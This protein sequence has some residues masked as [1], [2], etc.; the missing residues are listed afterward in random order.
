ME[1]VRLATTD[2]YDLVLMDMRMPGMDGLEAT[3][4]IRALP[5]SRGQVPIVAMTANALDQH[6]EECRLAGMVEHLAKPVTQAE[7]LAVVTR[8]AAAFP[9]I[10]LPVMDVDTMAQLENCM[11]SDEVHWLLD[12]LTLRIEALVKKLGEDDPFA[13]S[14]GLAEL[15]HEMA[16]SAGTLGFIRLSAAASRFDGAISRDP[17]LAPRMVREILDEASAALAELRRPRSA[18]SRLFA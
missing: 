17:G 18:G 3:R 16:G 5:G 9:R 11:S 4:R 6:A 13:A 1:A 14:D 12:C 2:D 7:L 10:E 8:V 15:A